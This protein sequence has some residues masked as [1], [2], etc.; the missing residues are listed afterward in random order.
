MEKINDLRRQ[1]AIFSMVLLWANLLISIV[2][3]Y[4]LNLNGIVPTAGLIILCAVPGTYFALTRGSAAE[5]RYF[6]AVS[7]V[8]IVSA[9]VKLFAGHPWQI[10]AHLYYFAALAMLA[11][12]CCWRALA[13]ATVMIALHHI[14]LNF[15]LPLAV[16]PGGSDFGRVVLHAIIVL[17]EAGVLIWLTNV[18]ESTFMASEK[19]L[20]MVQ[21]AKADTE[22]LAKIREAEQDAAKLEVERQSTERAQQQ[23]RAAETRAADLHR[24]ATA[25]EKDVGEIVAKVTDQVDRSINDLKI[26]AA[27]TQSNRSSVDSALAA[28]GEIAIGIESV[29]GAVLQLTASFEEINSQMQMPSGTGKEVTEKTNFAGQAVES[30]RQSSNQIGDIVRLINDIAAQTNLLALNA[31][32]E[33]ARAGD[34]GKGFAVVAN[35]V[36]ALATQTATATAEIASKIDD[37]RKAT[38]ITVDAI[39]D[40]STSVLKISSMATSV[41]GATEEQSSATREISRVT[42]E[43]ES[44]IKN[45]SH[46]ITKLHEISDSTQR[47]ATDLQQGSTD[48]STQIDALRQG[49]ERFLATLRT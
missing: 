16:F 21:D 29:T 8:V 38:Q 32:I 45:A 2:L 31:T 6:F 47:S 43:V 48:L 37:M 5:T 36:K 1:M 17:L 15:L 42:H 11:G 22:R 44:S 39:S 10:D 30:L 25:F 46:E 4:L 33:A 14:A 35:E 34:A 26:L 49:V 27:Q 40:I 24:L 41:A 9:I 3:S 19:A 12:F 20:Q 23:T 28:S 18:L 7:Y 13:I